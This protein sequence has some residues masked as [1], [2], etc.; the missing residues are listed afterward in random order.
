MT[1]TPDQPTPDEEPE[2][3]AA[4]Q[5]S[6]GVEMGLDSGGGTFEPEEDAGTE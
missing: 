6:D 1:T 3:G 2:G 5:D 4:P